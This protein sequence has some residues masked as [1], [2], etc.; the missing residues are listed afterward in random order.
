M[1]DYDL[2]ILAPAMAFIIA[3]SSTSGFRDHDISLLAAAWTAPLLARAV[4]G[5]TSLPLGLF[6][7]EMLY[8]LVMRRAA[9][10]RATSAIGAERI[11]QA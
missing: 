6:A 4:A 10:E 8:V 3:S 9:R 5:A 7:V 11:A 1:L 2:T